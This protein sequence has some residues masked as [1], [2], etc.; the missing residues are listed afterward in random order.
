MSTD[1]RARED[2]IAAEW[3]E[4]QDEALSAWV[5]WNLDCLSALY[6]PPWNDAAGPGDTGETSTEEEERGQ[7]GAAA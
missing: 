3:R 5:E 2:Q 4:Q 6:D 7:S 1:D